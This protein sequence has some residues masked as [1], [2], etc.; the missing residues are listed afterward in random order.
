MGHPAKPQRVARRMGLRH[1]YSEDLIFSE[2]MDAES[3]DDGTVDAS[4]KADNHAAAPK[5]AKDL[6]A[7]GFCDAI[8]LN[9]S[10]EHQG[11]PAKP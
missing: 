6:L 10:I 8:D 11:V 3:R 2:R 9:T 4:G 7:Q 5:C 1:E